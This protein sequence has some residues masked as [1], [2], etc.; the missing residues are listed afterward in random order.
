MNYINIEKLRSLTREEFLAVNPYPYFNSEGVLTESGFQDLLGNMPPQ[1][2]FEQKF[3]YERRA[4]QAQI[5][6]AAQ[7]H[8]AVATEW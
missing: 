3:G 7:A 1:E 6:R 2:M 5:G 8:A 4:G